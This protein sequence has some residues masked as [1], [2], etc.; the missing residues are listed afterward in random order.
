M[1]ILVMGYGDGLA[2]IIGRK[3]GKTK[4]RHRFTGQKTIVGSA[5]MFVT[6]SIVIA[7]FSQRYNLGWTHSGCIKILGIA[8]CATALELFTPLGLDNLSVPII[9]ALLAGKL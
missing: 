5:A 1:G 9:T 2:A 6:S 3:F 4:I 7:I 8:G